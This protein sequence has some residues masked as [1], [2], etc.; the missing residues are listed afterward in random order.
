MARLLCVFELALVTWAVWRHRRGRVLHK[1]ILAVG[2]PGVLCNQSYLLQEV[3]E[4]YLGSVATLAGSGPAVAKIACEQ[5]R[6]VNYHGYAMTACGFS[7]CLSY[8][9]S[10]ATLAGS[11]PASSSWLRAAQG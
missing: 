2:G 10:A 4:T 1:Q 5:P 11:G 8:L 7:I 6:G 3:T 9:G